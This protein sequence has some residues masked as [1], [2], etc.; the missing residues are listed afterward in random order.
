MV[1][2]NRHI[3]LE[4]VEEI[5]LNLPLKSVLRFSTVSEAWN[6]IVS[7][8]GFI[9][10]YR[11][12]EKI[13]LMSTSP[14]LTSFH[15]PSLS[16]ISSLSSFT[17]KDATDLVYPV[18]EGDLYLKASCDELWCFQAGNAL[19]LG[20]PSMKTYRK[21]PDPLIPLD[22]YEPD[23][24]LGG[25]VYGLGYD[26]VGDDYK[27]LKFPTAKETESELYSLKNDSWKKISSSPP[28]LIDCIDQRQFVFLNGMLHCISTCPE[29]EK[30]FLVSFDLSTEKYGEMVPPAAF[31]EWL[32]C[33]NYKV[34][35]TVLRGKLCVYLNSYGDIRFGFWVMEDYG[36]GESWTKLFLIDYENSNTNHTGTC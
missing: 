34:V 28:Y 13:A 16:S 14:S 11:G 3:P 6:S 18:P 4:I 7:D 10:R 5:L 23:H 17:P 15:D 21:L 8:L 29:P 33:P 19:F 25:F 32:S 9:K 2:N 27:L 31:R 20:N 24:E 36:V 12:R 1:S 30:M 35:V 22:G 26:S